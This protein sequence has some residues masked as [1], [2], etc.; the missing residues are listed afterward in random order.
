[1]REALFLFATPPWVME[2]SCAAA[3]KRAAQGLEGQL[4][5]TA[6]GEWR[7]DDMAKARA[8]AEQQTEDGTHCPPLGDGHLTNTFLKFEF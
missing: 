3:R 1:M 7:L 4:L 8:T 2:P 5:G 6:V